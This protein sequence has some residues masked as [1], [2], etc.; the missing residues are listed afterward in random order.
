MYVVSPSFCVHDIHRLL[1]VP[2]QVGQG[3]IAG[4]KQ[5]WVGIYWLIPT[6]LYTTT[7]SLLYLPP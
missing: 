5:A 7:V 2:L 3:C 1:A 6:I 4:P